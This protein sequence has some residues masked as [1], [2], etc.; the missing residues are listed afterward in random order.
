MRQ[1]LQLSRNVPLEPAFWYL[2]MIRI[3]AKLKELIDKNGKVQGFFRLD[4]QVS[5]AYENV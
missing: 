3:S 1:I 4:I 5:A 2:I